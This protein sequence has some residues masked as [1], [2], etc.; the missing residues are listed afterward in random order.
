MAEK[1]KKCTV[2]EQ[3]EQQ[4]NVAAKGENCKTHLPEKGPE[5]RPECCCPPPTPMMLIN[6][7]SKLFHDKIR[8]ESERL[9]LQ[10]SYRQLLFHLAYRD[11]RT[12]FELAKLTHLKPPTVSV[13]L[14]KME[15]EGYV[16]RELDENDLRQT[17]VYITEQGRE[18]SRRMREKFRETEQTAIKGINDKDMEIL[19]A[20]L[21]KIRDNEFQ[22]LSE[23]CCNCYPMFKEDC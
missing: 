8:L 5:C 16:R 2:T 14:Q 22:M 15:A 19:Y 4:E 7:V 10:N 11:G 23:S 3:E 1:D 20:L 6:E 13:A 9:N 18:A 17:L 21:Y 12:Q